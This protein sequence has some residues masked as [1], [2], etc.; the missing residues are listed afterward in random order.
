MTNKSV[1]RDQQTRLVLHI[2][3]DLW[4]KEIEVSHDLELALRE[5]D[6]ARVVFNC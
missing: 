5:L 1:T 2:P 4:H 6:V 3:V